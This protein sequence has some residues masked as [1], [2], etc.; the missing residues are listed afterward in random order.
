M[1]ARECASSC[2][3]A[4][5]FAA[6]VF[7]LS[8]QSF[9]AKECLGLLQLHQ[10]RP[11]GRVLE[12]LVEVEEDGVGFGSDDGWVQV[13]FLHEGQ[14]QGVVGGPLLESD[15]AEA[16]GAFPVELRRQEVDF[17]DLR[18]QHLNVI[19]QLRSHVNVFLVMCSYINV[20]L[21]S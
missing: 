16:V 15:G 20:F 10:Y 1:I 8:N 19:H 5:Q 11:N 12:L 6:Y 7:T 9:G 2:E 14:V 4:T 21:W 18:H 3:S 17:I 13:D